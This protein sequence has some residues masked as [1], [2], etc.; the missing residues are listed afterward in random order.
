MRLLIVPLYLILIYSVQTMLSLMERMASARS[1]SGG[2]LGVKHQ[3][4]YLLTWLGVQRVSNTYGK[5]E[6]IIILPVV[7]SFKSSQYTLIYQYE[8]FIS[9]RA[10]QLTTKA[11]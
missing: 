8:L 3:V 1:W 6:R 11:L 9:H 2:C 7:I 4:T 5:H 10:I